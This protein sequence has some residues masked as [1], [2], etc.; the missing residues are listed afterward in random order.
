MT[1]D[2]QRLDEALR[3][4]PYERAPLGF[5]ALVVERL[6]RPPRQHRVWPRLA[7]AAALAFLALI[8]VQGWRSQPVQ[9]DHA[10][11]EALQAEHKAIKAELA[12]LERLKAEIDPALDLGGNETMRVR[13]DLAHDEP[14][15]ARAP[16]STTH[17]AVLRD[18]RVY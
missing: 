17:L 13:L 3:A 8:A 18:D 7:A 5:T 6:E 4:L 15:V 11:L 10:R 9:R 16:K 1:T 12:I 14:Q 2:N